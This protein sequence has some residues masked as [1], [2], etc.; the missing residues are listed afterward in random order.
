MRY[1]E[2]FTE[3]FC[4]RFLRT[5]AE[6]LNVAFERGW[7]MN[8]RRTRRMLT[9]Y[10]SVIKMTVVERGLLRSRVGHEPTV[11]WFKETA[12]ATLVSS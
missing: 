9:V 2:D 5:I 6:Y 1:S 10:F 7:N 3:S 4:M 8:R 11:T 12:N